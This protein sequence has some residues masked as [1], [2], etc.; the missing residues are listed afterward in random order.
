[1]KCSGI[2]RAQALGRIA[3]FQHNSTLPGKVPQLCLVAKARRTYSSVRR[4]ARKQGPDLGHCWHGAA[5]VL[6]HSLCRSGLRSLQQQAKLTRPRILGP[7]VPASWNLAA[8]C[9]I[10][11]LKRPAACFDPV[12]ALAATPSGGG[13]QR[14]TRCQLRQA[15]HGARSTAP[16]CRMSGSLQVMAMLRDRQRVGH[17]QSG[18]DLVEDMSSICC[19]CSAS[20]NLRS[21]FRTYW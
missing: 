13:S 17:R 10:P 11:C 8:R 19:G 16:A 5:Q 4:E 6:G 9:A 1:M 15:H 20:Q 7:K 14:G 12:S 21:P 2:G 18:A 3:D